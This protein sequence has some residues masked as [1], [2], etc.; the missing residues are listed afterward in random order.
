MRGEKDGGN[1]ECGENGVKGKHGM[2]T[3]TLELTTSESVQDLHKI[4]TTTS[5]HRGLNI[6]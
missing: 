5:C 1:R 2:A 3:G 6:S 4:G